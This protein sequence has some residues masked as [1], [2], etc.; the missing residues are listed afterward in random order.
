MIGWHYRGMA[1]HLPRLAKPNAFWTFRF[2]AK[3]I[4]FRFF[5]GLIRRIIYGLNHAE[6]QSHMWIYTIYLHVKYLIKM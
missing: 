2:S 4:A 5:F 6:N 1:S 3:Q